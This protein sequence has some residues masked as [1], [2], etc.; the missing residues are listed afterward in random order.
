MRKL[1]GG[2][3]VRK[4]ENHGEGYSPPVRKS[5]RLLKKLRMSEK[6][7][8]QNIGQQSSTTQNKSEDSRQR[9][10]GSLW[11]EI[12][13]DCSERKKEPRHWY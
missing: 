2:P 10:R 1:F 7:E 6:M 13:P 3:E 8:I 5:G 4:A 11:Q 12:C 9:L